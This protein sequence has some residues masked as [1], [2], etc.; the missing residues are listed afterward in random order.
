[1]SPLRRDCRG[2]QIRKQDPL[3]YLLRGSYEQRLQRQVVGTRRAFRKFAHKAA[4]IEVSP[5][6]VMN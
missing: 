4:F 1:M 5:Q 3:E 6:V 2:L